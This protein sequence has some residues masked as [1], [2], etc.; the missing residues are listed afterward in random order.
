MPVNGSFI[1]AQRSDSDLEVSWPAA[2]DVDFY[3]VQVSVP[4]SGETAEPTVLL[5]QDVTDGTSCMLNGLPQNQTLTLSVSCGVRYRSFGKERVRLG[6]NPMTVTTSFAPPSIQNISYEANS[7]KQAVWVDYETEPGICCRVWLENE[8][9]SYSQIRETSENTICLTFGSQGELE[10][11][12]FG[13]SFHLIL[14][15]Y[16]Q[17]PGLLFY[18]IPSEQVSLSRDDLLG[19]DLNAQFV[20][21]GSNVFSVSWDETKGDH[22][23]VQR[24]DEGTGSWDTVSQI[25]GN[26]ERS[27]TSPHLP[28]FETRTYR[29]AAVGGE[30]MKNSPYA[31][32]SQE[33]TIK[34]QESPIFCTVWPIKDLPVYTDASRTVQA[35]TVDAGRAM[36]VL[37]EEN[38]MFRVRFNKEP[39]YIDSS[40]CLINLPEYLGDLVQYC[41]TNSCDCQYM[42]HEFEIPNMTGKVISGYE[43]MELEDGTFLAPL[44]YPTAKKLAAAGKNALKQGYQLKIYDAFRPGKATDSIYT[45]A[46][47]VL[48]L[49]IPEYPY[50]DVDVDDLDLP[51]P[52]YSADLGPHGLNYRMVMVNDQYGLEYFLASGGSAHNQGV[53]MD[54][55]M[56]SLETGEEIAAQSSIHDLSRYSVTTDNNEST[57]YLA[58]IMTGAGFSPLVSEWWHFQDDQT[59]KELDPPYVQNGLSGACWIAD[60]EGWRYR[61]KDGSFYTD[62]I[63]KIGGEDYI[64][65]NRGYFHGT[66]E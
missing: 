48:D 57:Q 23:E 18:G 37:D 39:G 61:T 16:R 29:V 65:D 38:G 8:D 34:T 30:T 46:K 63:A 25:S 14:D 53:A 56:V 59:R 47:R 60:E 27:Y 11:P 33:Y 13:T 7:D 10:V 54:L 6:D 41:I 19:R 28:R 20:S 51:E 21:C 3:R 43:N 9:G 36:C 64:F 26:E 55:T 50:H 15:A 49:P 42:V 62:C 22:Y 4:A 66:S 17:E 45:Q 52:D 35:G 40:A 58:D 5:T 24:L 1:L 12:A 44:L 32:V 2:F 31:A